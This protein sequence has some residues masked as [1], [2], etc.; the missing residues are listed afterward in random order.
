MFTHRPRHL[1]HGLGL[2]ALLLVLVTAHPIKAQTQRTAAEIAESARA[3]IDLHYLAGDQ[4]ALESDKTALERAL[5]AYPDEPSLLHYLG[6]VHWR[7]GSLLSGDEGDAS[8]QHLEAAQDAL[9]Q[10]ADLHEWPETHAILA[11]V[12]G[13]RIGSNPLRGMRLGP[14]ADRAMER[15]H[16]LDSE[17]PR[18]WLLEGMSNLYKPRMFGGGVDKALEQMER[19]RELFE[20]DAP[21]SPHPRW[22]HAEV[23]AWLGLGHLRKKDYEDARAAFDRSLAVEP[24]FMWVTRVLLPQLER[25]ESGR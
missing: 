7:L 8:A 21:T 4:M 13:M 14:R 3:E 16:E 19:A 25:A 22:G 12:Y 1:R 15:A 2:S 5:I 23:H 11:S 6:F 18:V 24:E 17:N 20:A 10:A 9:E